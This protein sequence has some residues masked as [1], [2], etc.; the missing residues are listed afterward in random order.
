MG[1][2]IEERDIFEMILYYRPKGTQKLTTH[3]HQK[4]NLFTHTFPYPM[5]YCDFLSLFLVVIS[6]DVTYLFQL[7]KLAR[8]SSNV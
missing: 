4:K 6:G 3:V 7:C 2:Q 8:Y 1:R 5:S